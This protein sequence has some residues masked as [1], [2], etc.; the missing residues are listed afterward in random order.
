MGPTAGAAVPLVHGPERHCDRELPDCVDNAQPN[1]HAPKIAIRREFLG[2]FGAVRRGL[3]AVAREHQVGYP[4]DVDFRYHA[5][6]LAGR[7]LLMVNTSAVMATGAAPPR[8][9]VSAHPRAP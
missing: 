6:R 3:V 2:S 4:P 1:R 5:A 8:R 7:S 9:A